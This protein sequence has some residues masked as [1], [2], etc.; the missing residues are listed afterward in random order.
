MSMD[1]YIRIEEREDG[2]FDIFDAPVEFDG[3]LVGNTLTLKQA[4]R[5]SERIPNEYGIEFKLLSDDD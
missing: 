4:I 1:N 3:V 5:E 2:T